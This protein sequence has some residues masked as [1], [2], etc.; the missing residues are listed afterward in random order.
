MSVVASCGRA[1]KEAR[2]EKCIRATST[3]CTARRVTRAEGERRGERP[4]ESEVE[5]ERKA[6]GK[7]M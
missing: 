2:D 3:Q 6:G 5:G 1:R 4:H 7:S